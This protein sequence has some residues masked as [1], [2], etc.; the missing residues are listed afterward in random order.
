MAIIEIKEPTPGDLKWFGPLFLL[1][2]GLIGGLL[3][4][5]GGSMNVAYALWGFAAVVVAVYYA[6]P[7]LQRRIYL[8]WIYG[9]YPIGYVLSHVIMGIVFYLVVT[10]VG[11][12]MRATGRDP[13]TRTFD[14]NAKSYWVEHRTGGRDPSSYFRQF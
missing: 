5:R 14:R 11:L 3:V 7:A 6:M 12:I 9:V 4:W 2:F 8:G 1:F 10:P 13:M